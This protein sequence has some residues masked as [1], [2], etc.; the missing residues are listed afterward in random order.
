MIFR[1]GFGFIQYNE[2]CVLYKNS[3][4]ILMG[5]ILF[6]RLAGIEPATY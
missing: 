6:F 2:L 5:I 3:F 1:V 4:N